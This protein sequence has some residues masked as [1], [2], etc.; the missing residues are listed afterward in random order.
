ML[1]NYQ[2]WF[3][4]LKDKKITIFELGILNGGSLLLWRD[5]FKNGKVVGLDVDP[6]DIG[7]IDRIVTYQGMQQ[8]CRLLKKIAQKEASKGF[9]I[10]IDDASH[11]GNLTKMSFEF[12]FDKFLKPG[13]IYVIEDW[14]TGYWSNYGDG[15]IYKK[16]QA[17]IV[18]ML[19][20]DRFPSHD[21]G[22]V[23]FIKQ[24]IDEVG[25]DDLTLKDRGT[26]E[27]L[28][29]KITRMEVLRGQIAI[30]KK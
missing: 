7:K 12:L 1:D 27:Q 9:D 11:F 18:K 26:G 16:R 8:D 28:E 29:S 15:K 30:F 2:R 19:H 10:I 24:L 4:N 6:V 17:K 25:R 23:G 5:Y 21:Y 22:M 13:G 20:K 3:N 14:G